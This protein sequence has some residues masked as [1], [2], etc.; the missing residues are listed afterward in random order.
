MPREKPPIFGKT[1]EAGERPGWLL[2]VSARSLHS[3]GSLFNRDEGAVPRVRCPDAHPRAGDE[4]GAGGLHQRHAQLQQAPQRG[5]LQSHRSNVFRVFVRVIEPCSARS[6]RQHDLRALRARYGP[7][8]RIV[9]IPQGVGGAQPHLQSQ[10]RLGHL[11]GPED[12]GSRRE[13]V[14]GH[15]FRV[16]QQQPRHVQR[17]A[18][19]RAGGEGGVHGP[20]R[21]LGADG[22][23]DGDGE[24]GEGAGNGGKTGRGRAGRAGG[25]DRRGFAARGNVAS[26]ERD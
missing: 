17:D 19:C 1:H 16:L 3:A 24:R 7:R 14:S 6:A 26:G 11:P 10:A 2:R 15:G 8:H 22:A 5:S 4:S 18:Q 23:A 13:R 25:S 12:A 9:G 20:A 21:V